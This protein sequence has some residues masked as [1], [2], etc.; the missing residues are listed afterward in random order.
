MNEEPMRAPA[1]AGSGSPGSGLVRLAGVSKVFAETGSRIELFRGLDFE[2][3]QGDFLAVRGASGVGKSTLLHLIGLLDRPTE[4][5]VYFA[6][7]RVGG[8]GDRRLSFIRTR[9]IGFVFQFHH[10]L[11]EFTVWENMLL[12]RRIAGSLTRKDEEHGRGLLSLMGVDHR[13]KHLPSELSGGER[14]RVAVA[15]ALMNHPKLLLCDEPSGNLDDRNSENLHRLLLRTNEKLGVA[16]MV[17]THDLHLASLAKDRYVLEGGRLHLDPAREA[18][19]SADRSG[20]SAGS[21]L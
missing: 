10:L 5:E 7:E 18:E 11:P 12:P 16:I 6:G 17:V 9:E 13:L 14:Q 4:G 15:R 2:I 3:R 1:A 19:G 21:P 20:P 8:L